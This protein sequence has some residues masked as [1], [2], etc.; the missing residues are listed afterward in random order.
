MI[1]SNEG[2]LNTENRYI[3]YPKDVRKPRTNLIPVKFPETNAR[4]ASLN[5]SFK[6]E[7]SQYSNLEL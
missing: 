5:K 1:L 7:E 6:T 3:L 2:M 4:E